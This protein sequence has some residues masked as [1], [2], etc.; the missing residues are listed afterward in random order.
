MTAPVRT[1]IGC[2]ARVD[3]AHLLRLVLLDGRVV[4]DTR[5]RMPGRGAWIHPQAHCLAAAERRRAWGRALRTATPVD[6][7]GVAASLEV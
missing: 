6:A 4:V 5:R 1:C 3:A 2:R 7:S